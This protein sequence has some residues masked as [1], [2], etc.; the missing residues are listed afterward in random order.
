MLRLGQP[1]AAIDAGVAILVVTVVS[2][3]GAG[4]GD[5][6]GRVAALSAQVHDGE[7]RARAVPATRADTTCRVL[8]LD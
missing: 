4:S 6:A 5:T 2:A 8:T 7:L 1:S 3:A